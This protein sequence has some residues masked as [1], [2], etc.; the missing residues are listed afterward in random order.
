M[1]WGHTISVL[2]LLLRTK[3][4]TTFHGSDVNGV[5]NRSAKHDV[6]SLLVRWVSRW[7]AYRSDH[8]IYVSQHLQRRLRSK[9]QFSIIPSGVDIAKIPQSSRAELRKELGWTDDHIV[10]LFIG[11]P[12]N[13]GKRY[14]LARELVDNCKQ[15]YPNAELHLVWEYLPDDIFKMMKAADLLLQTS[16]QEGSPTIVKEALACGLKIVSTPVGDVVERLTGVDGCY[17]AESIGKDDL[18]SALEKA[19][20]EVEQGVTLSNTIDLEALSV[21]REAN[22]VI[23]VYHKVLNH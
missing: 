1:H 22:E 3:L 10:I 13:V 18:N 2:P 17:V 21:E 15:K 7:A 19:L 5:L 14:D 9:R 23:E 4:V 12:G 20:D 16:L 6:I 8:V 11:N